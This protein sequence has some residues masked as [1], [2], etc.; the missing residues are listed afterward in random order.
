MAIHWSILCDLGGFAAY[1]LGLPASE[2]KSLGWYV[3]FVAVI[4]REEGKRFGNGWIS[5]RP[6]PVVGLKFRLLL[7]SEAE[8]RVIHPLL[9]GGLSAPEN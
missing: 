7:P 8:H 2:Y 9:P 4:R 3:Q 6:L 1:A 5:L